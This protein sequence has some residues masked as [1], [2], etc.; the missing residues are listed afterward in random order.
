[1]MPSACLGS[2]TERLWLKAAIPLL[3]LVLL[4]IGSV[5]VAAAVEAQSRSLPEDRIA[6]RIAILAAA[7]HGMI[8]MLPLVLVSLFVIIPSVCSRIFSTFSCAGFGYDDALDEVQYFLNADFSLMCD[9]DDYKEAVGLASILIFVWPVGIPILFLG[10]LLA[11][12]VNVDG[13]PIALSRAVQFL[14]IE[15]RSE[16]FYWELVEVGRKLVLTGFLLLIP[17]KLTLLRLVVAILLTIAHLVVLQAASPYKQTSTFMVA[18]TVGLTLFCTLFMALLIL[19]YESF[20]PREALDT[21]GFKDVFPLT[22]LIIIFNALAAFFG[23]LFFCLQMRTERRTQATRRL[24]YT[25]RKDQV[26][27]PRLGPGETHLFLSHV[28]GTG[29]DQMRVVKQRLVEMIPDLRVWLDVDDLRDMRGLEAAID[30]TRAVLVFCSSGYVESTNCMRELRHT[31]GTGKPII[32]LLELECRHGGLSPD[33]MREKLLAYRAAD[34]Q[35][36]RGHVDQRPD[37]ARRYSARRTELDRSTEVEES[38]GN[39]PHPPTGEEMADALFRE[40]PIEWIR[41]G[42]FQDV[43]LRLIA[44]RVLFSPSTTDEQR[45]LSANRRTVFVQGELARRATMANFGQL[46]RLDN[47]RFQFYCSPHNIGAHEVVQELERTSG[48][49]RYTDNLRELD[50]CECM[51]I[52]L[53]AR[54]WTMVGEPNESAA[55]AMEVARALRRRVPL[56]LAHEMPGLSDA[57]EGN[58]R[59]ACQFA[60]FFEPGHTPSK[61]LAAG[62]YDEIAVALKGGPYREASLA[63]LRNKLSPPMPGDE[64]LRYIIRP[65]RRCAVRLGWMRD[66]MQALSTQFSLHSS[67]KRSTMHSW[68]PSDDAAPSGRSAWSGRSGRSGRSV[69]GVLLQSQST[70]MTPSGESRASGTSICDEEDGSASR[71]SIVVPPSGRQSRWLQSSRHSRQSAG[72]RRVSFGISADSRRVASVDVVQRPSQLPGQGEVQGLPPPDELAPAA[73]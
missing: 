66:T 67:S 23:F 25:D 35:P 34:A 17:L 21:F 22:V 55:F 28:W 45:S 26:H 38:N 52:H 64:V 72:N 20:P 19:L 62:V 27:A 70:E 57:S 32:A 12:R 24:R 73:S 13:W 5:L 31:V 42:P 18:M 39:L 51:F 61:L 11:S 4:V 46:P 50:R 43:T 48:Q 54:T 68:R 16:F 29:Q 10:L 33:Q 1:V 40:E 41:L 60:T 71:L 2:F 9:G 7:W 69:S 49:L 44:Q 30:S 56:V 37:Q 15:Y 58:T 63:L 14:H 36:S 53:T 65:I 6:R 59:Y 47:Q 3:I 8:R